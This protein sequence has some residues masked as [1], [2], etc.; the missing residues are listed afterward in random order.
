MKNDVSIRIYEG[1][2][3]VEERWFKTMSDKD[4]KLITEFIYNHFSQ[5]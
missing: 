4:Y 1:G 3:L 5:D 2:K